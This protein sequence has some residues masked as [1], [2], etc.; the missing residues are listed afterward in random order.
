M[1]YKYTGNVQYIRLCSVHQG[2]T[3]YHEYNRGC[4]VYR[5][6]TVM[7]VGDIMST[8]EGYHDACGAIS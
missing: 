8:L 3:V 5:R 2:D 1:L 6:D 7:D 4:S